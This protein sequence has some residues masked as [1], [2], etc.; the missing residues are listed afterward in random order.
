M[1]YLLTSLVLLGALCCS[2]R[3]FPKGLVEQQQFDLLVAEATRIHIRTGG[4]C[5]RRPEQEV[6]LLDSRTPAVVDGWKT[7]FRLEPDSQFTKT[8]DGAT[9]IH[10]LCGCCGSH[11]VTFFTGR[12]RTLQLSIHHWDHIRAELIDV[13]GDIDL[14]QGARE[15]VRK[16]IENLER[17]ANK[18]L[19]DIL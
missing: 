13:S 6:I 7:A 12:Q 10:G 14:I 18:T 4:T 3:T 2:C 16:R 5:H 19:G 9:I 8:E 11:T 15:D 1:K 17:N